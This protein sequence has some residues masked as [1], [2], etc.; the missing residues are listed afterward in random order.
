MFR[1]VSQIVFRK[2]RKYDFRKV[3]QIQVSQ[4]YICFARFARFLTH[5]LFST[6]ESSSLRD[7]NGISTG[8][9]SL[10][11]AGDKG[12]IPLE[13]PALCPHP[14]LRR[15]APRCARRSLRGRPCPRRPPPPPPQQAAALCL[16]APP[17]LRPVTVRSVRHCQKGTTPVLSVIRHRALA[18]VVDCGISMWLP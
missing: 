6:A 7:P 4:F 9:T 13:S 18:T 12:T 14:Q 17:S 1:Q 16:P 15:G 11:P 2:F 8:K 5:I 3:S 10:C